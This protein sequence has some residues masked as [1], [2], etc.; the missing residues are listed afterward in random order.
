MEKKTLKCVKCYNVVALE[1][2]ATKSLTLSK[3]YTEKT[4]L[5]NPTALEIELHKYSMIL[6]IPNLI[7][8]TKTL[9]NDL[10]AKILKK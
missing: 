9:D 3:Y 1:E 6:P 8:K 4:Y 7:N 10:L 5:D 2:V